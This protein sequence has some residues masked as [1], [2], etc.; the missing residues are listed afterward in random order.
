L[1]S[2]KLPTSGVVY[3]D[4]QIGIYTVDRHPL[5]APVCDPLWEGAQS[6]VF[7]VVSS[8]LTLLEVLV[9][10][11]RAGDSGLAARRENLWRRPQ[12]HFLP[13][14]ENVLRE[15]ARLRASIPGLRTPDA[16]HAATALLR[17][18]DLFVTNDT[19]FR[20]VP[21]LPFVLLDDALASP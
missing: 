10:P 15:A 14:S 12:T 16:I 13:I 17:H 9:G 1:G 20:R 5:Y 6:G 8:E 18:C 4:A 2:L 19:G 3:A 21:S 11:V 7:T